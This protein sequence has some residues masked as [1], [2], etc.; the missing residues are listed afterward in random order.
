[1]LKDY[2]FILTLA[3]ILFAVAMAWGRHQAQFN[4]LRSD[5]IDLRVRFDA[6]KMDVRNEF[7]ELDDTINDM[8][9][10]RYHEL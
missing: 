4:E 2:R 1:M 9:M 8:K 3:T 10:R 6:F 7:S 5:L